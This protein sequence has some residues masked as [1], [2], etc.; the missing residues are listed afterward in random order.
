MFKVTKIVEPLGELQ[1]ET[2]NL[3]PILSSLSPEAVLVKT[4]AAGVCHT[5]IHL[6]HGCYKV[7][8]SLASY[9]ITSNNFTCIG[10]RLAEVTKTS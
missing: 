5:D 8:V 2:R 1:V 4:Q 6:W 10:Y 7:L 9:C 3:E